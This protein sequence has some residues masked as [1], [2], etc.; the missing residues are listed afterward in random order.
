MK[1]LENGQ[2]EV[3]DVPVVTPMRRRS[4]LLLTLAGFVFSA[5]RSALAALPMERLPNVTL[6]FPSKPSFSGYGLSNVLGTLRFENPVAVASPPGETNRLFVVERTGRIMV[7]TNL[8]TPTKSVFLDGRDQL[9]S[10]NVES[11]LL[12]LAFHPGYATNGYFYTYRTL[13][14]PTSPSTSEYRDHLARFQVSPSNPDLASVDSELP[15]ISQYDDS[16][17]HNAGDLQFGPDGY[18]Y[19]SLGDTGPALDSS[20]IQYVL[21]GDLR[22]GI[23]RIDVDKRPENLT[24]NAHPASTPNYAIPADN[25]FVGITNYNGRAVDPGHV[26]T[27]FFAVGFRNPWRMSFDAATGELYCGDVGSEVSEELDLVVKGG[28]YGWPFYEGLARSTA[29]RSAPAG[30]EPLAPVAVYGR[31]RADE[32]GYAIVGG[33]VYHGQLIPKIQN[34]Y[35][36]GD[37]VS[38][39]IWALRRKSESQIADLE[40]L[41]GDAGVAAFGTDPR[42]GEILVVNH[43]TGTIQRLVYVAP[44]DAPFFPTT[45]AETGAFTDLS[46]LTPSPGIESYEINAPFWSDNAVKTRWFSVPD[47]SLRIDFREQENWNFPTGTVWVKH[48]EME[49]TN[50]VPESRRRLETRFIVK[51]DDGVYG[52]TYRW[53]ESQTNATLVR[54]EGMTE[55]LVIQEEGMT[56][57]QNWRYPSRSECLTCH[58]AIGGYALGFNTA[59][60]NRLHDYHGQT[61]NQIKVLSD[62]GYFSSTVTQL[63]SLRALVHPTNS[64]AP[65]AIRARSYLAANCVQCHQPKSSAV[66]DAAW[67]ARITTRLEDTRLFAGRYLVPHAPADSLLLQR[68]STLDSIMPP[69]GTSLLNTTGIAL[70]TDWIQSLPPLPWRFNDIGSSDREGSSEVHEQTTLVSGYG[71]GFESNVDQF[72][73]LYQEITATNSLAITARLTRQDGPYDTAKAGLM[74]RQDLGNTASYAAVLQTPQGGLEFRRRTTLNASPTTLGADQSI[75]STWLKLIKE[76]D[77]ISGYSSPDGQAWTLIGEGLIDLGTTAILGLVS[78]A[79]N[80]FALNTAS[81]ERTRLLSVYLAA[82]TPDSTYQL[83]ENISLQVHI[84]LGVDAVRR[85][86]YLDG[87]NQIGSSS[88][89]PFHFIWTNAWSGTHD[90]S[91]QVVDGDG[92]VLNS[93]HAQIHVLAAKPRASFWTTDS[94]TQGDW[95]G[96]LGADGV[97]MAGEPTQQPPGVSLARFDPDTLVWDTSATRTQALQRVSGERIAAAWHSPTNFDISVEPQDGAIHRISLYMVDYDLE[98]R[99]Q[100]IDLLDPASRQILSSREVS[101]FEDGLY[102]SWHFRGPILIRITAVEGSAAVSGVFL[103]PNLSIPPTL[104]LTRPVDSAV[105]QLPA[106]VQLEAKIKEPMDASLGVEY[107]ANGVSIGGSSTFPY[108]FAWTNTS[109]GEIALVARAYDDLGT[110]TESSPIHVRCQLPPASATYLYADGTTHGDWKGVYGTEGFSIV[111]DSSRHPN[112]IELQF[113]AVAYTWS[114]K[115]QSSNALQRAEGPDRIAATWTDSQSFNIDLTLSDGKEYLVSLYFLDFDTNVRRE[116][117]TLIDRDTQ[118]A[119]DSREIVDFHEGSYLSWL[120]R[121]KLRIEIIK[122][123][124]NA[125]LSAVFIDP[126]VPSLPSMTAPTIE[127]IGGTRQL[128]VS[129]N[130]HPGVSYNIQYKMKLEDPD[131][132]DLPGLVTATARQ[133]TTTLVLSEADRLFYRVRMWPDSVS[134]QR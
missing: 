64:V 98:K 91:A 4:I 86:V 121:G 50:G 82:P 126:A 17:E 129:W 10:G 58:T 93:S 66:L 77:A 27:E 111:G 116:S 97:F 37:N 119:L 73:F 113:D 53:D 25:P 55:S 22:G 26:R 2:S 75:P 1:S 9:Y 100:R 117:I 60:L 71:S 38:G 80:P 21:D 59:Q 44:E 31:G 115:P 102:L 35:I 120:L 74:L 70:I 134:P 101:H 32:Q 83:P 13:L 12:G 30:L 88:D 56:R 108:N 118:V 104:T 11:G 48:F 96:Q 61:E 87:T 69:V 39:H 19:I 112:P 130:S 47:S 65:V 133:A 95:I 8:A 92:T 18:L 127:E 122:N 62:A 125:V 43:Q 81:F 23:L 110:L 89:A 105:I 29:F 20:S 15:L 45:L 7:V 24:P 85:V 128:H 16:N 94:L 3:M 52:V 103:D 109:A 63:E 72:H 5:I 57:I 41:T 51:N 106:I 6:Q 54:S 114:D 131:W 14:L 76:D 90:I 67:D 33:V 40:R 28:N 49:M 68:I 132:L 46:D 34:T 123:L 79:G 36:F 42:D 99:M 84:S 107:Y 78:A 124:G